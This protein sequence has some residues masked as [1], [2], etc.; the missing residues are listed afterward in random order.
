MVRVQEG[1]LLVF[2]SWLHHSVNPN[3]SDGLRI[4][5]SFNLMFQGFSEAVSPPMWGDRGNHDRGA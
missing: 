1:T 4:S 5:V 2:P 3:A